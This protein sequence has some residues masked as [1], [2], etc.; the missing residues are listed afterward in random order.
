[1]AGLGAA[2]RGMGAYSAERERFNQGSIP[3]HARS[4]SGDARLGM[5]RQGRERRGSLRDC[6]AS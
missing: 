1:M 2:G 5:A 3:R 4:R 6:P